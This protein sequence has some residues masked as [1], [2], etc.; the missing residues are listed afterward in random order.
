MLRISAVYMYNGISALYMYN[1]I[2]AL[3]T[4]NDISVVKS[5]RITPSAM[6]HLLDGLQRVDDLLISREH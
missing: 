6:S 5:Q 2:S 4:Y 3:Y 1:G